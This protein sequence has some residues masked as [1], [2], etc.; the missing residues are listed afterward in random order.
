M[1][2]E[3]RRIEG[4]EAANLSRLA[5]TV[6]VA[7]F[8]HSFS[9]DDLANHLEDHLSTVAIRLA[10]ERDVILGA[11]AAKRLVGFIQFGAIPQLSVG[12]GRVREIRRLYVTPKFQRRGIGSALMHEALSHPLLTEADTV[13]LDVWERNEAAQGFYR[14]FGF[15]VVGSKPFTFASGRRGDDDLI[16]ARVRA[17]DARLTAPAGAG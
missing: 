7:A 15:R 11:V 8:G 5:K 6:F 12:R 10:L 13:L 3:I 2:T 14:K 16:M 9:R 1:S 17:G 4:N